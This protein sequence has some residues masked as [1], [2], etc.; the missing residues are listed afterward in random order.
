MALV[1]YLDLRLR[2]AGHD[3]AADLPVKDRL[4]QDGDVVF[5][6]RGNQADERWLE[7]PF[8]EAFLGSD[9]RRAQ[10]NDL[11]ESEV[12]AGFVEDADGGRRVEAPNARRA[13]AA[14][15]LAA[16]GA[17]GVD[18]VVHGGGGQLQLVARPHLARPVRHYSASSRMVTEQTSPWA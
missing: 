11:A 6:A 7:L 10:P 16:L 1:E 18:G 3:A 14:E 4:H 8:G 2:D 9:D 17:S 15:A 5:A 12:A 13:L